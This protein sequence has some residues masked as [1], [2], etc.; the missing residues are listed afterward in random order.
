MDQQKCILPCV[1]PLLSTPLF[2]GGDRLVVGI[3]GGLFRGAVNTE[4]IVRSVFQ[5]HQHGSNM[6]ASAALLD[7]HS[8][9]MKEGRLPNKYCMGADNT[10]KETKNNISLGSL[11]GCFAYCWIQTFGASSFSSYWSVT[12]TE[13]WIDSS[14]TWPLCSS[15]KHILLSMTCT[16]PSKPNFSALT[17]DVST[18]IQSGTSKP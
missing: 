18:N 5:D 16:R 3:V 14:R 6:Q 9:A 17:F 2:K 13:P 10:Y 11:C 4:M 15:V 7:I 8:S 1:W 12:L